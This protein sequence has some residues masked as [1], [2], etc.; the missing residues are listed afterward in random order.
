MPGRGADAM[1]WSVSERNPARQMIDQTLR[2][3]R[4]LDIDYDWEALLPFAELA[5]RTARH[6]LD[7]LER[8]TDPLEKA[9]HAVFLTFLLEPALMALRRLAQE[10]ESTARHVGDDDAPARPGTGTLP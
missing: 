5:E 2:T 3:L 7:R 6:D 1:G 10:N 8:V 4:S 9:E